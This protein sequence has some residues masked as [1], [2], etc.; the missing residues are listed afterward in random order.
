MH[1]K[2]LILLVIINLIIK[3]IFQ[4]NQIQYSIIILTKILIIFIYF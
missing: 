3:V 4:L 1:V 2:H